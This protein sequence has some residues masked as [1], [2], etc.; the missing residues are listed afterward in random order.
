[1]NPFIFASTAMFVSL[2]LSVC[3]IAAPETTT[4]FPSGKKAAMVF[5]FDDGTLDQYEVAAPVLDKYGIKAIFNI[6]PSRIGARAHA[7]N[8]DQVRDLVK[9]GHDLG[10]HTYSHQNLSLLAQT[11]D[12]DVVTSE[13]L[14]GYEV[15]KEKTGCEAKVV[16]FPYNQGGGVAMNVVRKNGF[17]V[18][19]GRMGNWGGHFG[20]AQARKAAEKAIQEGSWNYILIH[21]V[22][23]EGGWQAFA[24]DKQ[25][26]AIVKELLSHEA[27]WIP[28]YSEAEA[29]R[30]GYA[31]HL[32]S[33]KA[34]ARVQVQAKAKEAPETKI[35]IACIGDSITF[36]HLIAD[37]K[38]NSYPAQLQRILDDRFPGKYRVR[39]FGDPGRGVYLDSIRNK[40]TGEKRGYRHCRQHQ[41]ALKWNPDIVICN[42]GINDCLEY[43]KELSGERKRGGFVEDYLTLCGDYSK[44]NP[45]VT[46]YI[47][48][49]LTPLAANH[50]LYGTP[51]YEKIGAELEKA[52]RT[53]NAVP[54]D[55]FSPFGGKT[56]WKL[57]RD[58]IHPSAAGAQVIAEA[59]A[60]ALEAE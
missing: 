38:T 31:K 43:E 28:G 45:D 33:N 40:T 11:G 14:L 32:N 19:R 2:Y 26:E 59:T 23:P 10:N 35:K 6:V 56:K 7:M 55:L 4:P 41:E 16:C 42:L 5:T 50:K 58:G 15:L 29:W 17:S 39:N 24:S 12:V 13:I 9:R 47:W 21:G 57:H 49:K 22:R 54:M 51:A 53:V 36:G 27:L 20:A 48:T 3:A 44:M 30:A 18:I 37:A 52:A 1:M 8:W 25:F 60:Q 34:E 46:F